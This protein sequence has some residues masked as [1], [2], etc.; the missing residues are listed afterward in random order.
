MVDCWQRVPFLLGSQ[1]SAGSNIA[2][3]LFLLARLAQLSQNVTCSFCER[4]LVLLKQFKLLFCLFILSLCS[5]SSALA[6][7]ALVAGKVTVGGVGVA[8]V[9]VK[10][11]PL[12]AMNFDGEVTAVSELSDNDGKFSLKL[13]VGQYYFFAESDV[14]FTY[15]GRN[16]VTVS[17]DGIDEMNLALVKRDSALP[18]VDPFI[19]EGVS[20][21]ITYAGKPLSGVLISIY[22]DLNTQLKGMGF[23][24][25]PPTD[26]AG[27]F[28]LPLSVGTYYLVA[29]KRGSGQM[30]GPLRAGDHFG[31]Y[32]GNPL[33]V[34]KDVVS[35]VGIDLMEVPA[36]VSRLAGSMFGKTSIQGKVLNIA[37]SPVV[38]VRVLLYTNDTMLNRPLYVSQP[39][40]VDGSYILSFP[41]GGTYFLAARDKLGGA[42]APGELYGRYTG[43][44]DSSVQIRTGQKLEGVDLLV[45]EMW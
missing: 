18:T 44:Q 32:A 10:A 12:T 15:Y 16:P 4:S 33:I 23:G 45:Q 36:K 40:A 34:K 39:S 20:G 41:K 17:G 27:Y 21:Q 28:E 24:I 13:K 30:S 1:P 8:G 6:A 19:T 31:Y 38:G 25:S 11:Y 5:V 35:L 14:Y 29:R 3:R 2:K 26:E 37:G 9:R 43:S 22:P 42:P 7:P